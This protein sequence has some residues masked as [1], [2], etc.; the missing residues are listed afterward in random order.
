MVIV[1]ETSTWEMRLRYDMFVMY[2][3]FASNEIG[4]EVCKSHVIARTESSPCGPPNKSLIL[5]DGKLYLV[6]IVLLNGNDFH[7]SCLFGDEKTLL[8]L[9]WVFSNNR[10]NW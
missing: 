8:K 6:F 7:E 2:S 3:F 1:G 10:D 9:N 4:I 5:Y